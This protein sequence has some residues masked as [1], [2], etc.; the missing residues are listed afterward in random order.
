MQQE[1][2]SKIELVVSRVNAVISLAE[3][4]FN[5]NMPTVDIRFDLKGRAAGIAGYKGYR[6]YLRFNVDMMMNTSWDHIFDDTIPHEVAHLV[7]YVNPSLGRNHDY[8]WKRVCVAL[9][10]NGKRCHS[11]EVVYAKG[12]TYTYISELGKSINVSELIHKRIQSGRSYRYKTGGIVSKECQYSLVGAPRPA[13][14]APKVNPV[15]KATI[16]AGQTKASIIRGFIKLAK[17]N[18]HG[19]ERVIARAIIEL[20]MAKGLATSYVKNN[21][22]K[23]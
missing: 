20:G 23:V 10:G 19:M 16:P 21:W 1:L 6:F 7:C 4:K 18:N 3:H 22:A 2:S 17:E 8:G 9:G 11:E 13:P 12:Q 14:K 5:I 15:E